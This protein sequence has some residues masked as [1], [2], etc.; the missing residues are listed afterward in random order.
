[1]A[2]L[3]TLTEESGNW[4]VPN[5]VTHADIFL[6]GGGGS[7]VNGGGG[8]GYTETFL[9][10]KLDEVPGYSSGSIP[11]VVGRGGAAISGLTENVTGN[12]GGFTRFGDDTTYQ[13]AGGKGAYNSDGNDVREGGDGGSGG[14]AS[15]STDQETGDGGSDGAN[16][17][18]GQRGR[19]GSGQGTTTKA[20]GE[21][22]GDLY[23]GGGAP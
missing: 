1:M 18:S 22:E 16:G 5:G 7:G 4:E 10:I 12:D 8:G 6:V 23:A 15:A 17:G 21:A 14:G 13:A 3:V 9:N 20:F 11:Y 19:G 2:F